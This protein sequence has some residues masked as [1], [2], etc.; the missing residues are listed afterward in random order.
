MFGQNIHSKVEFR[1][2]FFVPG[3]RYGMLEYLMTDK[4]VILCT[5]NSE[6][7]ATR[8]ARELV[9]RRLA[10][11]VQV[12]PGIRSF[13]HWKGKVEEDA[14]Y[15]LLIKSNRELYERLEA[16]LRRIH[17][18]EVPEIVALPVV[19]ASADYQAWMEREL[20]RGE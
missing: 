20:G 1:R 14:E 16:E 8:I 4:I 19:E 6:E 10:A 9:E 2:A 13:Y 15:L 3:G 7:Q 12:T 18:Y 5:C 17:S 11:C